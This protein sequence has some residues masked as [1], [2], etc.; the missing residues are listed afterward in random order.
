[1]SG[2]T[3]YKRNPRRAL[4]GMRKLTL[5][6][7]GFYQTLQDMIYDEGGP[8]ED[9]EAHIAGQM[10]ISKRK[11]RA[12]RDE[13]LAV[14]RIYRDDSGRLFDDACADV[15]AEWAEERA[16][17]SEG[18]RKGGVRSGQT[19]AKKSR[20]RAENELKTSRKTSEFEAE[21]PKNND[22]A[23]A[24]P[25]KK[26]E[27]QKEEAASSEAAS[28]AA[29]RVRVVDR[30][31]AVAGP[32][33]ADPSK[34]GSLHLSATRIAAAIAAGCDLELDILPVIAART[35]QPRAS[36]ITSWT[37]FE[38]AWSEARAARLAQFETA[39]ETHAPQAARP[40]RGSGSLV[41]AAVRLAHRAGPSHDE[42]SDAGEYLEGEVVAPRIAS[43]SR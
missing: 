17:K 10:M 40:R 27:V 12:L 13:L 43:A 15:L 11:Y 31:F 30:C 6:Q 3:W 24:E 42:R 25:A 33:L 8:V 28:A 18:G 29:P 26:I 20:K 14:G 9:D 36:P 41:D 32:G 38:R 22:L 2:P 4:R 1:M 7:R 23:E 35:A 21:P 34:H 16:A 37:Y 19:R 5:E 39:G